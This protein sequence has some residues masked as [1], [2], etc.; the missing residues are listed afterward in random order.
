MIVGVVFRGTPYKIYDYLTDFPLK[1]G[2]LVVVPTGPLAKGDM[3]A[4]DER[5][6]SI[7]K[8]V[9]RKTVSTKAF[10]WVIQKIDPEPFKA[11]M[12]ADAIEAMLE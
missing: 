12:E 4:F 6:L 7:A 10:A 5:F 8:V 1:K 3:A 11:R 9:R 2:D